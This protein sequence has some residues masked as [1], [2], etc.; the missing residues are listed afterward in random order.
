MVSLKNLDNDFNSVKLKVHYDHRVRGKISRRLR[1]CSILI[2][3]RQTEELLL[4]DLKHRK[5]KVEIKV[6]EEF[7]SLCKDVGY[8]SGLIISSKDFIKGAKICMKGMTN[9]FSIEV[10]LKN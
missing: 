8:S 9:I 5:N 2:T 6:V 3:N 7:E 10:D 4:V 1:Q